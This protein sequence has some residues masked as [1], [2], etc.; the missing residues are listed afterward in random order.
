[1]FSLFSLLSLFLF[2]FFLLCVCVFF[3]CG[4]GFLGVG[5]VRR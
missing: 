5:E 4:V 2:S 3:G 1:M